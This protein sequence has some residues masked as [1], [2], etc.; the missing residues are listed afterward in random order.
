MVSELTSYVLNECVFMYGIVCYRP[1]YRLI[2]SNETR[3]WFYIP[4]CRGVVALLPMM[5]YLIVLN[6]TCFF[7]SGQCSVLSRPPCPAWAS[8]AIA[9]LFVVVIFIRHNGSAKT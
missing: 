1:S 7:F 8:T 4:E 6:Y 2:C 9:D 5:F 3:H